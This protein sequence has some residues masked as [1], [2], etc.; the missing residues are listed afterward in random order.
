MKFFLPVLVSLISFQSFAQNIQLHYDL[1][2]TVDP[3]ANPR[4]FPTLYFEYFKAQ[5]SGRAFIKPGAFLFKMQADLLGS[6]NNIGKMYMQVAQTLR[7][8]KP[9]VFLHLSYQRR[10]W[11][12]RTQTIQLLYRQYLVGRGGLSVS[13]EGRLLHRGAGLQICSLCKT[14]L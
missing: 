9:Q 7:F 11:G 6:G 14:Q 8:W 3:A 2:H 1:R 10:A 12:Y 4:N 13:M 5:D